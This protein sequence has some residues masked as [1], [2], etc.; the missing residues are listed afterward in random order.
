MKYYVLSLLAMIGLVSCEEAEL[1][2]RTQ[3][4]T[5]YTVDMQS[6]E[7]SNKAGEFNLATA[8]MLVTEVELE[9]EDEMEGEETEIDIEGEY[10]VD[11]LTGTV[12]PEFPIVEVEP[13]EYE[14]L[15]LT[16]GSEEENTT[17]IYLEGSFETFANLTYEL[18]VE[19]TGSFE[20]EL[21][22]ERDN[23]IEITRDNVK[24]ILVQVDLEAIIAQLDLGSASVNNTGVIVI[25]T[26]S[27]EDLYASFM[28][29]LA[30]Q[31]E[32]DD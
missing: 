8:W 5:G 9:S 18:E 20:L 11:L 24:E 15:E 28:A 13:G 4:E 21:E 30:S 2:N 3:S 19:I 6:T 22:D 27:N 23:V 1:N 16:I 12:E 26:S 17:A 32:L 14:E 31:I 7:S 10:F 25:N 29:M